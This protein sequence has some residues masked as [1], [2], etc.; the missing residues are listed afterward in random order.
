MTFGVSPRVVCM[1]YPPRGSPQLLMTKSCRANENREE[2]KERKKKG[3]K[4][5]QWFC[6]GMRELGQLHPAIVVSCAGPSLSHQPENRRS[7][8]SKTGRKSQLLPASMR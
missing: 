2:V 6:K 8:G 1:A 5:L 3:E 7:S 4:G